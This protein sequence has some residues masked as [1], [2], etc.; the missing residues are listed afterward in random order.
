MNDTEK[1]LRELRAWGRHM[2]LKSMKKK[3]GLRRFLKAEYWSLKFFG[4]E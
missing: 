1:M 3:H 4:V 2:L